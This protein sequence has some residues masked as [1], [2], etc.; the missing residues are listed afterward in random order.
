MKIQ[1]FSS[2]V[3]SAIAALALYVPVACASEAVPV[4]FG[5]DSWLFTPYEFATPADNQDSL[6][7]RALPWHW[8]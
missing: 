3:C 4:L 2:I 5:K 1:R 7:T 6:K 8:L